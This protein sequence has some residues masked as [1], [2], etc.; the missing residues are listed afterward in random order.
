MLLITTIGIG[1]GGTETKL[2]PVYGE[3]TQGLAKKKAK[4]CVMMS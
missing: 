3:G 4:A 1:R 2:S